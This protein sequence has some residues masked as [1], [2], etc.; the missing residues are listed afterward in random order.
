MIFNKFRKEEKDLEVMSEE[1]LHHLMEKEV[2]KYD[3]MQKG[4]RIVCTFFLVLGILG[5]YKGLFSSDGTAISGDAE[6][7]T[8]VKTYAQNYYTYPKNESMEEHLQ[9]FT[10]KSIQ[11]T[12]LQYDT[13]V[14]WVTIQNVQIYKVQEKDSLKGILTYYLYGDLELKEKEKESRSMRINFSMDVLKQNGGYKIVSPVE[15]QFLSIK[16]LSDEGIESFEPPQGYTSCSE[17]E[18][19][20][21]ENTIKLFYS[22]YRE[23]HESAKLLVESKDML[24][25]LDK[26]TVLE[27][28]NLKSA[29]YDEEIIYVSADITETISEVMVQKKQAYFEINKTTN[30]IKKMEVY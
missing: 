25:E 26:N 2:K 4:K 10:L 24:N 23:N 28:V 19:K 5:G 1:E 8:F 9:N 18:K 7:Q 29:T 12:L 3:R 6:N 13:E 20:D 30:K 22:T 16:N 21:I 17:E 15:H 11:S 14:E 27:L